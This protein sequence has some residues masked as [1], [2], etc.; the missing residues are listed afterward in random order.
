MKC[1]ESSIHYTIIKKISEG[2]FSNV[3]LVKKSHTLY[4]LKTPKK[5]KNISF[6]Q[7]YNILVKL[8]HPFI[9]K[10]FEF[11]FEYNI[12]HLIMEYIHGIELYHLLYK[13]KKFD[14]EITQFISSCILSSL[15]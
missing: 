15:I 1:L 13:Y 5:C 10:C 3:Y 12:P 9:C 8:N 4:A 2:G 6:Q 7:E 11:Y 14:F